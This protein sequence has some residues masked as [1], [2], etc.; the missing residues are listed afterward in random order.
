MNDKIQLK[1]GTLANWLKADPILMDG[2]MALVATYASKPTVYDSQKVGDGIHKFSELEMYGNKCLQELGDS[3]QFPMSQ[4][5]ITDWINKGYQFRGIA[6]PDT[7]PGT[8]DWPVFYIALEPGTYANFG[9]LSIK[10]GE[11]AILFQKNGWQKSIIIQLK[12][13]MLASDVKMQS[14]VKE[15]TG[16][17][18]LNPELFVEGYWPNSLG[19]L[20]PVGYGIGHSPYIPIKEGQS[21]TAS[22]KTGF[23]QCRALLFDENFEAI[24]D[25]ISAEGIQGQREMTLTGTAKSKYAMFTFRE[26]PSDENQTMVEIGTQKTAYE[27][28]YWNKSV[29]TAVTKNSNLI[30]SLASITH[31]GYDEYVNEGFLNKIGSVDANSAY[32]Y[33]DFVAIDKCYAIISK[34]LFNNNYG[35]GISFYDK[36][37]KFIKCVYNISTK[38]PST[39]TITEIPSIAKY[40][41]SCVQKGVDDTQYVDVLELAK[42]FPDGNRKRIDVYK[43]DSE[44]DILTK[45]I[46]AF[47]NGNCDVYFETGDYTLQSVYIYMRDTLKWI[48]TMGLPIGNNCRYFLQNSRITSLQP[49]DTY[50]ATRNI[51]DSKASASDFE[52]YDGILINNG[53]TYCVHDEANT[54]SAAYRHLYKNIRMQYIK[55]DKTSNL[56]KCIGGGAGIDGI[57]HI[58]NCV[59]STN[60]EQCKCVSWHVSNNTAIGRMSFLIEGCHFSDGMTFDGTVKDGDYYQLKFIGNSVKTA[61]DVPSGTQLQ[62]VYKFNNEVRE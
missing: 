4:K 57:V 25:S 44:V 46:D 20:V 53:G 34:G 59:F 55:G 50:E 16:K 33:T 23:F 62:E 30:N 31:H 47:T 45:M 9:G 2:E 42:N 11:T 48:W 38:N 54:D 32:L 7:N 8:P 29:Q 14:Y 37:K 52:I 51:L 28:Y 22:S 6:T 61:K 27:P 12:S 13:Y 15:Q 18:I 5:A 41:R 19:E 17:N 39:E 24:K 1:R 36:N 58:E 21:L 3:Q 60:N 43:T 35:G 40:I 56:S 10:Y 49:E 26:K